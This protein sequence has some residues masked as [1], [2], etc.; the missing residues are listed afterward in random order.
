MTLDIALVF[1]ILAC[2]LYL[3]ITERVRMDVVALM[4][5][6][7]LAIT[8]LVTPEEA[9][10]GFSNAAVIAVWATFILSDGLTRTGISDL[11]GR[12]IMRLAGRSE[13]G[14][15][16]VIMLAAGA[17]SAFMSNIGVAALML[18]MVVEIS[19]RTRLPASR[20]L[21]PLAYATLLGGMITL[22][23]TPPNLLI[24]GALSENG[25]APFDLFD[26]SPLGLVLLTG[27]T[28]FIALIGRL[29]LPRQ[30]I[31]VGRRRRSQRK[32]RKQYGL[33]TRTIDMRIGE[34][35][36]LV[37]KTLAQSRIGAAAGLIVM[38]LQREG[39]TRFMPSRQTLLE[40]GDRLVVQGQLDQFNEFRRWSELVIE[41]EAP[42][43]Q[44]LVAG[45]VGVIEV[46]VAEDS[47]LVDQMFSHSEFRERYRA[48]WLAVR[49]GEVVRRENLAKVPIR[50]NDVLLLQTELEN[51]ERLSHSSDFSGYREVNQKELT[52]VY[53]LQEHVF[54]VRV[55]RESA[56]DGDSLKRS[57]FGDAFDFH[58]LGLF[59]EG[60]LTILPPAD[61]PLLGGDLMLIQG[62]EED[63]DA[64]R[65]LQELEVDTENAAQLNVLDSD[66]L[67][68]TEATLQP[69][70]DLFGKA[71]IDLDLRARYD[72]EVVAVWRNGEP[73]RAN[74]DNLVMKLGDALLLLGPREKLRLIENDPDYLLLTPVGQRPQDTSKAPVAGAI[75]AG[76]LLTVLI[77]WLPLHIAAVIGAT[78]MIL[79]GCLTMDEAYRAIEWRAIF[80]I[81]GMLPLGVAMDQSG[82]ASL[83]AEQTLTLLG[84]LGVWWVIAG[85]FL[86]T[87]AATI[88]I[89]TAAVV[90][91]M[92]PIVI[93]AMTDLGVQPHTA[94]MAIAMA[95]S[96]S[97]ISPI[98]HP[99]NLLVM[100][101]GGYRF[102]DYLKIGL[103]LMLVVFVLTM[104]TLPFF[105]P[106]LP[107]VT[108]P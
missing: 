39:R 44:S 91:L 81:A 107:A 28:L 80:L 62:R 73:I 50:A 41:R 26:F 27:G 78:A 2:A 35:S 12:V 101:P 83:L 45:H 34:D 63:L 33:H 7:S 69:H 54:V 29:W 22:I 17:L 98:S 72:L 40:A 14:M 4:V 31:E 94:M 32:L 61:V 20:L 102:V 43:L 84:P 47:P 13:I 24:S 86:V 25:F 82:A 38:A 85:L 97:F 56:L 48:N 59:R 93:T 76:V 30:K 79:S 64:L 104:I 70:S 88:V 96:A 92:S 99:A 65:G 19:R 16:F 100:G 1:G 49:R 89:P 8:R 51:V 108:S 66:R 42:V 9:V 58:L 71:L 90:V 67:S 15:V 21:M 68:L 3:L 75:I 23:G 37:G 105:W 11:I 18:P 36:I 52:D 106:V 5:L 95:A 57:R 10:A 77:G 60:E 87:A 103:P 53:R 74:L 55:P 6:G 46:G